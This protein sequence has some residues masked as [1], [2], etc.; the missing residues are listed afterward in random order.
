ML[1]N[2]KNNKEN[3][4]AEPRENQK[5]EPQE[6]DS[7]KENM[8]NLIELDEPSQDIKKKGK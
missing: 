6:S 4:K 7:E 8:E 3:Q 1:L 2:K 5:D